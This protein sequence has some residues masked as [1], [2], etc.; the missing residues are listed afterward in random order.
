MPT[1]SAATSATRSLCRRASRRTQMPYT[2]TA[3]PSAR[4]PT[5]VPA[6]VSRAARGADHR[7]EPDTACPGLLDH[8]A[9][10]KDVAEPAERRMLDAEMNDLVLCHQ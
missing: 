5:R 2:G 9:R 8:L 6:W 7:V 10:G 4:I 3:S 1:S